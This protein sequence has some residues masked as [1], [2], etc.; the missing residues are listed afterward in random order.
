[1]K[2]NSRGEFL[3]PIHF[4]MQGEWEV[5]LSVQKNGEEVSN[6]KFTLKI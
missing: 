3:L 1:M 5:V 4:A 6:E 2:K